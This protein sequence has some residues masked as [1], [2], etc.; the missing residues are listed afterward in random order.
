[1]LYDS[2][3][4]RRRQTYLKA[5]KLAKELPKDPIEAIAILEVLLIAQWL[6]L[7]EYGATPPGR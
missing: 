2:G 5:L 7:G 1:M 4:T 6:F 3:A